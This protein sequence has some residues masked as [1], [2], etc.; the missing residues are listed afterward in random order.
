MQYTG[1]VW[2]STSVPV[3]SGAFTNY[4]LWQPLH[5]IANSHTG[6][7]INSTQKQHIRYKY[8]TQTLLTV[9]PTPFISMCHTYITTQ[10]WKVTTSYSSLMHNGLRTCMYST[11]WERPHWRPDD[12]FDRSSYL[13][14]AHPLTTPPRIFSQFW[15][16]VTSSGATMMPTEHTQRI[17]VT[18]QYLPFIH[19]YTHTYSAVSIF[20]VS[21]HS[22][23][24]KYVYFNSKHER[25]RYEHLNT[26]NCTCSVL[27]AMKE[28]TVLQFPLSKKGTTNL[29]LHCV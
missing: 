19:T 20:V 12:A 7:H 16:F 25:I 5:S 14:V 8:S 4:Q 13:G 23:A 17:Y 1:V 29:R 11:P 15:H 26:I 21:K 10:M 3:Q 22:A 27:S 24:W 6:K 28:F 2:H 9:S 18:A